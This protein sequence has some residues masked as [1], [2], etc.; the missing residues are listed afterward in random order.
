MN[1]KVKNIPHSMQSELKKIQMKLNPLLK[2]NMK[3]GFFSTVMIGFS[4]INLFF[5]LFM[6]DS[7][8]ISKIALC[9][10]ALI[11]AIGFA[12]MK[13][14]KHNQK[15]IVKM[16]QKFVLERMK[17]S[18]YLTDARKNNYY[19]KVNEHP[20]LAMNVFIEFLAEEEQ[21]KNNSSHS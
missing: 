19:Q 20:F 13:E 9:I 21:R 16:S 10:Y 14:N 7:Y 18:T 12:L 8:P 1:I 3:Y 6:N 4:V 11:G 2:K 17:K 15:E 5:L